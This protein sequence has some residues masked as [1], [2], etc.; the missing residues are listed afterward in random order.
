MNNTEIRGKWLNLAA[1]DGRYNLILLKKTKLVVAADID[2]SALGKLWETTPNEF[3][4]K[5][6]TEV[7]DITKNFPFVNGFFD[8]VFCTGTLHL[9][10]KEI[11]Q[12][13]FSE[14][15][16]ILKPNGKIIF[17]FATDISRAFLDGKH[18]TTEYETKYSLKEAKNFLKKLLNTYKVQITESEVPEEIIK[19]PK[20][21][22][23]FNCKFLLITANKK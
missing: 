12:S 21:D 15:D 7:F 6:K 13:I 22:Y 1:G 8:G 18:Y 5:L 10:P 2:E 14:I 11:L 23:R 3:K 17:D 20:I 19:M 9:F 4:S 16:R